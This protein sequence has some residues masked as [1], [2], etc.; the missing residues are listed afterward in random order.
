MSNSD[1]NGQNHDDNRNQQ[2]TTMTDMFENAACVL[3]LALGM[4]MV[5]LAWIFVLNQHMEM[6][7]HNLIYRGES[8]TWLIQKVMR[9]K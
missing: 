5:V 2:G 7:Q 1:N 8:G 3:V 9:E 4:A 6:I